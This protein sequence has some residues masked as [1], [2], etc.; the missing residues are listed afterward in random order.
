[1]LYDPKW[2]TTETKID[3][4][5]LASLIAWLERQPTDGCYDYTC[6]GQ[7][8]LAQYFTDAGFK[9]IRM[10]TDCF[11]HG[12]SAPPGVSREEAIRLGVTY[13]PDQF[14]EVA[15]RGNRTFGA[16]LRRARTAASR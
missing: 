12:K 15:S 4:F 7:C 6:N 13:L 11:M 16:A 14:N 5:S 1:M 2:E 10:F 9:N 3:P 8:L